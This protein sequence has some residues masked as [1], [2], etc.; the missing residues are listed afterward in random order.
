MRSGDAATDVSRDPTD[1]MTT[2][3]LER[4]VTSTA[5]ASTGGYGPDDANA[6]IVSM[7]SWPSDSEDVRLLIR[8]YVDWLAAASGV[9]PAVVQ[10]SLL[11][12]LEA[13]EQWY[14]P[15][16]GRMVLARIGGAAMGIVGI[17][18]LER[19]AA[20]LKRLYLRPEARGQDLG[21]RI[22]DLAIRES[23]RLGARRIL[24]ETSP[25][26]MPAA[27]RIY[28][29]RGFRP[30]ERYSSLDVDGVIAMELRLGL[31]SAWR[32]HR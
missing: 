15:P 17:H 31:F 27:Y 20:E 23:R 13:I 25:E 32:S 30:V 6:S 2:S 4:R 24:L 3:D 5:P 8:E 21:R 28:L 14:S 18:V 19:G 11:N 1:V 9:D 22:V 16:S 29:E 10:P 12:E 26:V 7:A